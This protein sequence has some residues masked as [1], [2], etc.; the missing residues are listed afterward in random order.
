MS[1]GHALPFPLAFPL[2]ERALRTARPAAEAPPAVDE[3][4]DLANSG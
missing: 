4:A 3:A 1:Y 2:G